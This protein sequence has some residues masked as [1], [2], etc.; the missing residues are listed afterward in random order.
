MTMT[1]GSPGLAL[2]EWGARCLAGLF[3]VARRPGIAGR[4]STRFEGFERTVMGALRVGLIG[5]GVMGR[6]LA[7]QL[8]TVEGAALTAVADLS[9]EAAGR[10]AEQLGGPAVFTDPA[11]MLSAGV[12]DAVLIASPGFQHRPLTELAASHG[13]HVF[14]EKPMATNAD[15]CRAMIAA[16][17][18]ADVR[19][20]VGQVLRYHAIP[21]EVI[22]AAR[23]GELGELWAIEVTRIGGGYGGVWKQAWRESRAMS[24]GV[25]MEV[26]AHEIDFMR[27]VCGEVTRVYAESATVGGSTADFPNLN[28]I[29]LRFASGAVGMLHSSQVSEIGESAGCVQGSGGTLLWNGRFKGE[30]LLVKPAGGEQRS[31]SAAS[32]AGED[33]VRTELRLF[34]E[35]IAAGT[36]PPVPGSEGLANVRVAEAAY[37]SAEIGAPVDL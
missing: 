18:S 31:V 22:R 28:F 19:L 12:V 8:L 25:L 24:G 34:V 10:A 13:A 4:W 7:T 11:E 17:A 3:A 30:E 9:A 15:D 26:N 14:V 29:S 36:E 6:S 23:A 1:S 32:L 20:M 2:D 37:R 35:S 5:C 33:P 27:Q 16:A 21:G